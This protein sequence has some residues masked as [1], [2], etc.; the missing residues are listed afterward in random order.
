LFSLQGN[1]AIFRN[2]FKDR[3][4][5]YPKSWTSKKTGAKGYSPVCEK[6]WVPGICK[7]PTVKCGECENRQFAPLTD[8]VIRRH[9]DGRITAGVYPLLQDEAC[10]FLAV[11]VKPERS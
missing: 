1:V 4:D 8:E 11:D 2:F 9:L 6:E 7:K 10:H 5:V 3:E